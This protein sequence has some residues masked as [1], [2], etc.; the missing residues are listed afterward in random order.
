MNGET[1]LWVLV[2]AV[3]GLVVLSVAAAVIA[4]A[5]KSV[6]PEKTFAVTL[7]LGDGSQLKAMV[8]TSGDAAEVVNRFAPELLKPGGIR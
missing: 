3:V 2:Y 5:V 4:A 1:F 6:H 8:N 7:D